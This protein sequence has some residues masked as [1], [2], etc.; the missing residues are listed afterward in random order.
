M[1]KK[2]Y[3]LISIKYELVNELVEI[4]YKLF[5][6]SGGIEHLASILNG[7]EPAKYFDR[8][9]NLRYTY[10]CCITMRILFNRLFGEGRFA[11][12]TNKFV[13]ISR[14]EYIALS[15]QF[16][17]LRADFIKYL[18]SNRIEAII[19]PTFPILATNANS[20]GDIFHL[21]QFLFMY[22]CLDMPAGNIPIALNND[23]SYVSRFNDY[24]AKFMSNSMK[25]SL[26]LPIGVQVATLPNEDELCL[27]LMKEV[28]SFYSFDVN[29][30]NSS[31]SG[32]PQVK[33]IK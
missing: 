30:A 7:E 16:Y 11:D 22:N 20:G 28:D 4:G 9:V 27:R 19:S 8:M 18:K 14:D 6:N 33:I 21:G 15:R 10:N 17:Q 26:G 5:Y 25:D 13:K 12:I 3:D 32:T 1:S 2:G 23:V 31:V 24:F 29:F